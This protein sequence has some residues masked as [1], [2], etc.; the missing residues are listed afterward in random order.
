M[1]PMSDTSNFAQIIQQWLNYANQGDTKDL[2]ALYANNAVGVFPEGIFDGVAAIM[3][4]L[5]GQLQNGWKITK[6]TDKEDHPLTNTLAWSVGDWTGTFKGQAI[7]GHWSVLWV[8]Q[9]GA[10]K[11]QEQTVVQT[12][13]S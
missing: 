3:N 12:V 13:Q 4:D 5:G 11:I 7:R 9:S 8:Q 6:L 1:K 2:A 10:W